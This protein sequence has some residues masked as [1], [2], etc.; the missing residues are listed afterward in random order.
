MNKASR[1][2]VKLQFEL[3]RLLGCAAVVAVISSL[4]ASLEW[5]KALFV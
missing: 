5:P 1:L 4:F 3:G 2:P